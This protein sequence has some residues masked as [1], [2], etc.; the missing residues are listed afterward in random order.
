MNFMWHDNRLFADLDPKP[1]ASWFSAVFDEFGYGDHQYI[2]S[3]NSENYSSM[4]S[5][6]PEENQ[7]RIRESVVI[8]LRGDKDSNRLMGMRFG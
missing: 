6:L 5:L 4:L 1:R 8:T 3:L 7:K 2:A